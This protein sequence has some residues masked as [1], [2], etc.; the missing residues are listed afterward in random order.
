LCRFFAPVAVTGVNPAA[1]RPACTPAWPERLLVDPAGLRPL[2]GRR[3]LPKLAATCA[4]RR[5]RMRVRAY[6]REGVGVCG[7]V[8]WPRLC[9]REAGPQSG[10]CRKA[11]S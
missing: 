4:R 11:F 5:A 2:V 8:V 3:K 1:A 10:P 9:I 6:A 7:L